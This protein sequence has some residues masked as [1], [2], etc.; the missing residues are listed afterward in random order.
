MTFQKMEVVF[1]KK[2]IT[3][4][5]VLGNT[6][7]IYREMLDSGISH[8]TIV[9]ELGI[10]QQCCLQSL[11]LKCSNK[12]QES[13]IRRS[14]ITTGRSPIVSVV[15]AA[16]V[17]VVSTSTTRRIIDVS[18][19]FDTPQTLAHTMRLLSNAFSF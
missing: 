15:E 7:V 2:C 17:P 11:D 4:D 19:T 5:A 3:C 18:D 13:L 16:R 6:F 14:T 9:R 12:Y 1:S 10:D 8:D